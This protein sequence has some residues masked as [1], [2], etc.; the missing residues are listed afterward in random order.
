MRGLVSGAYQLEWGGG[1]L[2][3]NF[4]AVI[5]KIVTTGY[6]SYQF[7]TFLTFTIVYFP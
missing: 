1:R 4:V 2:D 3:N 6:I 5:I 7:V